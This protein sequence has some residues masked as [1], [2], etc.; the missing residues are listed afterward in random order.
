MNTIISKNFRGVI[1]TL[2]FSLIFSL[3]FGLNVKAY[4]KD[5]GMTKEKWG[6]DIEH[7][8]KE[9]PKLHPNLFYKITK[10]DFHKEVEAL[11]KSVPNMNEDEIKVGLYKIISAVGDSHTRLYERSEN[12]FPVLTSFFGE[13]MYVLDIE[14][15]YKEA[16]Y[17]KIV[18][19]NNREIKD[20]IEE[21]KTV[22]PY[23]NGAQIKKQI[24][25]IILNPDKLYGLKITDDKDLLMITFEKK[26]G[27]QF[28]IKIKAV[29]R[30]E[31][32]ALAAPKVEKDKLPLY[33]RN[34]RMNYW[35]EYLSDSKIVYIAY[36]SCRDM[37]EKPFEDFTKEIF[38]CIKN[39]EVD[40]VVLDM[41]NNGGGSD[42]VLN[43]LRYEIKNRYEINHKDKLFVIVGR[44]TFSSA[45]INSVQLREETNA[46]FVG[47]PTSGKPN[48]FGAVRGF[49]LPN[50][51]I[52]VTYSTK[53]INFS[54]FYETSYEGVDSFI[55]D[56]I[57]ENSIEDYI[58]NRDAVLEKIINMK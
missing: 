16:L 10:E 57:V 12:M 29:S 38:Q 41:R 23:E 13:D 8:A 14:E 5:D 35:F 4:S 21:F 51:K 19:I 49:K 40:K 47:E 45:L 18:K 17:C 34:R 27:T 48:H 50:S 9:L 55:P 1:L 24:P 20:L 15:Q 52:S 54:D 6:E 44:N 56:V 42:G 3:F 33:M 26:D 32:F 39:K 37:E 2:C 36:N 58:N 43:S 46:T 22:I 31:K 30:K 25:N 7:L 11:K 53:H 28:D